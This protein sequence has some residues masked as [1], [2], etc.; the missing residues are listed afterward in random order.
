MKAKADLVEAYLRLPEE[1]RNWSPEPISRTALDQLAECVVVNKMTVN[2]LQTRVWA[3]DAFA[4]LMQAKEEAL[5]L[6]WQGLKTLLDENTRLLTEAIAA[7][8]EEDLSLE[9]NMPWGAMPLSEV[10][11]YP[12]WNMTYHLG[13][14]N[15]IA[16]MLGC[17]EP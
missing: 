16:S 4:K 3:E 7:F 10:L 9:V 13:Q 12:S 15:Y 11:A 2:L 5:A 1:K 6:E 8:P 17:L 14:I